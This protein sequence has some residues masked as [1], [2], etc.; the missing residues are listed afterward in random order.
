M[1]NRFTATMTTTLA[2]TLDSLATTDLLRQTGQGRLDLALLETIQIIVDGGNFL[3]AK[4]VKKKNLYFHKK[5]KGKSTYK[6]P[7]RP[8]VGDGPHVLLG[9]EDEFVVDNP[10]I[11]ILDGSAGVYHDELLILDSL[12]NFAVAALA[13]SDLHEEASKKCSSDIDIVVLVL[14]RSANQFNLI[15]LHDPFEL[16]AHI[17]GARQMTVGKEVF[18]APL[19]HVLAVL[20]GALVGVISV[21]KSKMIAVGMSELLLHLIGALPVVVGTDPYLRNREEGRDGEDLIRAVEFR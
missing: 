20:L 4:V 11:R 17:V 21:Q 5:L 2:T 16:S 14:E 9:R 15:D 12:V 7:L 18:M 6:K 10:V 3:Q 8:N 1:H 19:L 13:H